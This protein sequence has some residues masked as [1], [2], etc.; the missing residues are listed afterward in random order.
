MA[1]YI[2]LFLFSVFISTIS[3]VLLKKETMK[4]HK[5]I[6]HEYLNPSVIIA[7]IF[8][9]GTTLLG[10][11]AYKVIPLHL[12][13]ILDSSSYIYITIFGIAIFKEKI[14]K[15]KVVA[16]LTIVTGIVI[17]AL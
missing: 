10:V 15:Q 16:L 14:T 13:P 9:L 2:L 3:Q 11:W 8:F 12:G 7:Y 1:P 4:S 17:F 5:K 6:I